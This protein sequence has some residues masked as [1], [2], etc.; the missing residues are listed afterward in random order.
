MRKVLID[1]NFILT[2]L[3]Q[4]V[5]FFEW[6]ELNG[7]VIV[8]P[9]QVIGE[10]ESLERRADK[11]KTRE[12]ATLALRFLKTKKDS[13][14]EI[15]LK[16]KFVDRAIVKYLKNDS[17]VVIATIDK[18]LKKKIS[19]DTAVIRDLKKIEIVPGLAKQEG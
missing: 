9:K 16:D 6:F 5:D 15:D 14:E 17:K 1:T 4:K 19:N 2:C 7:F 12:Q 18:E 13:F 3:R 10:I 8:I 11:L